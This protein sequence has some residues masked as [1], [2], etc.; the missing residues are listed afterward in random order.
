MNYIDDLRRERRIAIARISD[1]IRGKF[2][3]LQNHTIRLKNHAELVDKRWSQ[4]LRS[5]KPCAWELQCSYDNTKEEL[6][7]I[8][9]ILDAFFAATKKYDEWR[10]EERNEVWSANPHNTCARCGRELGVEVAGQP[11]NL[12]SNIMRCES[13]GQANKLLDDYELGDV[14]S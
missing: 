4:D 5:Y 11:L 14:I 7:A 1:R 12:Q 9:K 13:C 8:K 3:D 2:E 6:D 10:R